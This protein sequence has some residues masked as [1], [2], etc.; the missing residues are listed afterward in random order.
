MT[1]HCAK[2]D[3][4][5]YVG[6]W[7]CTDSLSALL[8]RW[9]T[10]WVNLMNTVRMRQVGATPLQAVLRQGN[11]ANVGIADMLLL[12]GA[13]VNVKDLVSW[14]KTACSFLSEGYN[15]PSPTLI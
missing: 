9:L 7:S 10:G 2:F 4:H 8:V 3:A 15:F 11:R 5:S 12:R 13:D 14:R 6:A 1:H